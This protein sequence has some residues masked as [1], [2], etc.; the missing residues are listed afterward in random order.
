MCVTGSTYLT[1][2][3]ALK[4]PS[5]AL[6]SAAFYFSLQMPFIV[7]SENFIS[8]FYERLAVFDIALMGPVTF[9]VK[10]SVE[11]LMWYD[12]WIWKFYRDQ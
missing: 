4:Q 1:V 2:K 9:Y 8:A 7:L 3:H 10:P 5:Y 11:M 12:R 6:Q